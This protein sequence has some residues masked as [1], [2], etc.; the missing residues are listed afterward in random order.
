MLYEMVLEHHD[1]GDLWQA[2]QL[3]GHLYASKIYVQEVHRSGGH[4]WV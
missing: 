1:I 4:N 3:Q 2:V